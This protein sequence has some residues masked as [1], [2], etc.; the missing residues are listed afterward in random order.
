MKLRNVAALRNVD[1]NRILSAGGL[2][3]AL[4]APAQLGGL[5]TD[6]RI[7]LP[8]HRGIASEHVDRD[9]EALQP[10]GATGQGLLDDV[11]E[12]TAVARRSAKRSNNNL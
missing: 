11:L 9:G 3:V 12:E 10:I 2:I 8:I 1:A 6:H 5:D 4:Q 7:V